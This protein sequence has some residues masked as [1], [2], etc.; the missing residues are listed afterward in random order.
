[1]LCSFRE[2]GGCKSCLESDCDGY[3]DEDGLGV[4]TTDAYMLGM[5]GVF[6][7]LMGLPIRE[8]GKQV[9]VLATTTASQV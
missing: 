8:G 5:H 3:F 9:V 7:Q 6:A 1:M 2:E 4:G